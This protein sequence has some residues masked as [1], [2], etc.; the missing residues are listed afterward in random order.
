MKITE[1]NEANIDDYVRELKRKGRKNITWSKKNW[2]IFKEFAFACSNTDL[3]YK[4][5]KIK[6]G[7]RFMGVRHFIKKSEDIGLNK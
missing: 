4:P 5:F 7:D 3:G 1:I 2:K 6:E